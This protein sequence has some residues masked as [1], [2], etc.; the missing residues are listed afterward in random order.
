MAAKKLPAKK[1][2]PA[3][4]APAKPRSS[5]GSRDYDDKVSKAKA[6]NRASADRGQAKLAR[7]I[8]ANDIR[9]TADRKGES[10]ITDAEFKAGKDAR[11][12]AAKYGKPVGSTLVGSIVEK[13]NRRGRPIDNSVYSTTQVK[14]PGGMLSVKEEKL[15]RW[16]A[17]DGKPKTTISGVVNKKSQA[18]DLGAQ[19]AAQRAK[20]KK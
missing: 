1:T 12:R 19:R 7:E 11:G 20:K 16:A 15:Q 13:R 14:V 17:A 2:A 10:T 4:K 3:K 5:G 6:T 8:F 9:S 18:G